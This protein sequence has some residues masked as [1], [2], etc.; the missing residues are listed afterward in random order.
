MASISA[1]GSK[2]QAKVRKAG[3]QPESRTFDTREEAEQWAAELEAQIESGVA[4]DRP[5]ADITSIA[6]LVQLYFDT[7]EAAQDI[8]IELTELKLT[9]GIVE[10]MASELTKEDV[11]EFWP[12]R[13]SVSTALEAVI[14]KARRDL[15]YKLPD[16]PVSAAY[17]QPQTLRVRRLAAYEEKN[18]LEEAAKSRGGYLTDVILLDLETGLTQSE[19]VS[20]DWKNVHLDKAE[21]IVY[22][23]SGD[24]IIP[25]TDKAVEI[26][27]RRD[28]KSTGRVF[29]GLTTKALQR[30]FIRAAERANIAD[31]HFNDL[32]HEA[33][34]RMKDRYSLEQIWRISGV[35]MASLKRYFS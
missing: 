30:A 1:R 7:E 11:L 4:L 18:V 19:I 28:P 20:L 12:E 14:E 6:D 5:L 27:N 8:A 34:F 3:A 24:R 23:R 9:R 2:W 33:I 35:G 32:R 13:N 21:A 16:N 25:L 17:A 29:P 22:G 15:G 10:L 31:F 26:L